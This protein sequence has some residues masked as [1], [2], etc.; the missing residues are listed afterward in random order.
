MP[1]PLIAI[2]NLRNLRR[3]KAD[4][5][6]RA[7]SKS[8]IAQIFRGRISR[9]T[10][11]RLHF[12]VVATFVW[13]GSAATTLAQDVTLPEMEP[14]VVDSGA[15]P[16]TEY[17]EGSY[18]SQD[19]GTT[20]RLR[21]A[22]EAF[23][24]IDRGS[25]NIGTMQV[26]TFDDSAAFFDGQVTMNEAQGIGYNLGA[27][28]RWMHFPSYAADTG[29]MEGVSLWTDGTSNSEGAF[30][31]QLGL[32]LE[33]LGDLWDWRANG[34]LPLGPQDQQGEFV[35][36]GETGFQGN[37][38]SALSQ[39]VLDTSY[40]VVDLEAAR[41]LGAERDAWAFAGPYFVGNDDDDAAGFRVGVRGYAY[42]DLLVQVAV[43]DDEIFQTNATFSVVWFV[44][45]TRTDFHPACGVP[46]RFRE[47]VMRN[48]YVALSRSFVTSG[49]PLTNPDGTALRIVH[50][51]GNTTTP[52]VGTFESPLSED[53]FDQVNNFSQPGD[54]ILAWAGSVFDGEG[55][56][57]LQ[58]EQR[59]LGEGN[60]F[61]HT[62]ATAEQGAAFVIP[63]TSPGARDAARPVVRASDAITMAAGGNDIINFDFEDMNGSAIIGTGLTANATL[64]ELDV[65]NGGDF[66]IILED[67]ATTSTITLDE[68]TYDGG[69]TGGGIQLSNFDG[70]IAATD[71][72]LTNGTLA[73]LQI[74]GD[75]DGT[76]TFA[77]TVIFDSV[78]GTTI[79]IDGE[80]AGTDSLGGRILVQGAIT[81]D[82]ARSVSVQ[83]VAT[84]ADIDITG[85]ITDTGEGIFV[86][87]N[88]GGTTTFATGTLDMDIDTAGATAILVT[89][90]T[91]ATIQFTGPVDINN[92][93]DADG[94]VATGGGTFQFNNGANTI[95]TV[96]GQVVRIEDM[97]IATGVV[98]RDINRTTAAAESAVFLED[99][100]G[101][102]IVLGSSADV[103]P[104]D[105]GT[106]VGGAADTVVI[107]DSANVSLNFVIINNAPGFAGVHVEKTTTGNQITNLSD[108]EIN[109]GDR[110]IEVSGAAGAGTLTMDINDATIDGA[111]DI[112]LFIDDV[113]AGTSEVD[114]LTVTVGGTARG[115][116]L[117]N[118]AA[119]FNFNDDAGTDLNIT[120]A[121]GDAFSATDGG[122]LTV[123]G[124]TNTIDTVDGA[125]LIIEDYTIGAA[126]VAFQSV[127]VTDGN[128]NGIRLLNLTGG[129][130]TVGTLG[131]AD[132]SG[133][134]LD[135]DGDAIVL[136]NVANVDLLSVQV[137]N[138]SN[139]GAQ[140]VNID[141]TTNTNMDV[142]INNLD[143]LASAG[144]GV[145]VDH[146]S[147]N[148]FNLRIN[149]STIAEQVDMD[150]TGSGQLQ[151]LMDDTSVTTGGT[152]VAFDLTFSGSAAD[153]DV[154]IR[155]T[156]TFTAANAEAFIL[157]ADG[158]GRSIEVNIDN[159]TF[160]N[161]SDDV[162]AHLH[163]LGGALLNATVT[164]NNFTNSDVVPLPLGE[165]LLIESDDPATVINLNLV[166]NGPAGAQLRLREDA[167]DFNVVDLANVDDNNPGD[168]ILDGTF[169]SIDPPATVELPTLPP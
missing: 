78:D 22:T 35:L 162:T 108:L 157:T 142:T 106:L 47:P 119:T 86:N 135:T 134:V 28:Y 118:S 14:S 105:S 61:V 25:F 122:T 123:R 98:V 34:Y 99:N 131:G 44:G 64:R 83:N 2:C 5:L 120:T 38:I 49:E 115:V 27:G 114:N 43:T 18:F 85:N 163:A 26:V 143:L 156:S 130:V 11:I 24:Q 160:V 151:F 32:S 42:P 166:N 100:T 55:S 136:E 71:S 125:G 4:S 37:S 52:G 150:M 87:S 80:V 68:F 16:Y 113:D 124:T 149:A 97:T 6:W 41:R 33:S 117:Q 126:G 165:E 128:T 93:S 60:G 20:L 147:A 110:G 56:A 7:S 107:N 129:Q 145:K 67:V 154:T 29:R 167:G 1:Q 72:T 51:N 88:S 13:L 148:L 59:L 21:Y 121:G 9:L 74:L 8:R 144:I 112:G 127:D 90:N 152:D 137:E 79:D 111:T 31:P 39:A 65:M 116:V 101:A 73:G 95:S 159:N 46:D 30:F 132:A 164:N 102:S 94:L 104:G 141:H 57:I 84:G 96:T 58:D 75:S 19:L 155:N 53:Q 89:D 103:T 10:F 146:S 23:G 36:T 66:A 138:A 50:V 54:I 169:D 48:D 77:S 92:T 63:E 17:G 3:D 70:T 81:N 158:V 140:G 76:M 139:V 168:V 62:V 40:A 133:G 45:R 109:G 161:N 153:G 69:A 91:G 82:T 15:A 12:V